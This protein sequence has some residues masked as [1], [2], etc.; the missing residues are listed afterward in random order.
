MRVKTTFSGSPDRVKAAIL[1]RHS[2]TVL[3]EES[4]RACAPLPGLP[5]ARSKACATAALTD[6]GF[7]KLVAA[8]SKYIV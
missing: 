1:S 2:N 8:L 5:P 3:A 6:G 4:A 7:G